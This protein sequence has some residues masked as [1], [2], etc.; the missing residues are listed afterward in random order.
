MASEAGAH[1]SFARGSAVRC[2]GPQ[3]ERSARSLP[4]AR[5]ARLRPSG[6]DPALRVDLGIYAVN[7]EPER[8]DCLRMDVVSRGTRSAFQGL[9]RATRTKSIL[10]SVGRPVIAASVLNGPNA[11]SVLLIAPSSTASNAPIASRRQ[12]TPGAVAV[13]ANRNRTGAA[14]APQ[15]ASSKK[16]KTLHDRCGRSRLRLI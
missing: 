1:K 6:C 11:V 15:R 3:A 9:S 2:L 13:A 7:V 8:R 4:N 14:L 12:E 16:L 5:K 10:L